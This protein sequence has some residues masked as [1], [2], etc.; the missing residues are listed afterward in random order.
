MEF[1]NPGFESF[2]NL[3][4]EIE[5]FE[6]ITNEY[7]RTVDLSDSQININIT[8]SNAPKIH[9]AA[10]SILATT[11]SMRTRIVDTVKTMKQQIKDNN[12]SSLLSRLEKVEKKFMGLLDR[13]ESNMNTMINRSASV[14]QGSVNA[15]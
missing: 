6:Y 12:A 9:D 7:E 14:I 15:A 2:Q 3:S 13:M 1:I 10:M 4:N 5:Y 8:Q 11:K